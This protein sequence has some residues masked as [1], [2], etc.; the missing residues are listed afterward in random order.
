MVVYLIRDCYLGNVETKYY[1]NEPNFWRG[2]IML[3]KRHSGIGGAHGGVA[4][5]T[6]RARKTWRRVKVYRL[7]RGAINTAAIRSNSELADPYLR[8]TGGA[9]TPACYLAELICLSSRFC[10]GSRH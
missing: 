8:H 4:L 10:G 3:E 1:S 9:D 2:S 7:R 5:G 6:L